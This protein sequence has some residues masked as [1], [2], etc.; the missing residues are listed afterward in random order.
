MKCSES[1]PGSSYQECERDL[2]H[3][4]DHKYLNTRWSRPEPVDADQDV[5]G[6]LDATRPQDT[7]GV[8]ERS[9][10]IVVIETTTRLIWVDAENEDQALAYWGNDPTDI[11]LDGAN[12]LDGELEFQR[13][14]RWQ[15]QDAFRAKRFEA[16]IG[17][18]LKCP[19]CDSE[20]FSREWIHDPHR[21][22][23]GPIAWRAPRHGR[24]YREHQQTPAFAGTR[25][26]GGGDRG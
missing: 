14:D 5:Q 10:P 20:A 17:P 8:D 25:Q 6:L 12:V 2:E 3:S 26:A 9:Y 24:A 23:H 15:R 13:P 4:G 16:K 18:L 21:K 7:W 11:D 19:G 22:C 1:N